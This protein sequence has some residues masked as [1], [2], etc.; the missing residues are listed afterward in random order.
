M[1]TRPDNEL[2]FYL[3][4]RG[5]SA[6]GYQSENGF[7]VR[8]NSTVRKYPTGAFQRSQSLMSVRNNLLKSG[9]LTERADDLLMTRDCEFGS[10]STAASLVLGCPANGRRAWK[11]ADGIPLAVTLIGAT[12]HA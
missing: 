4:A 12:Q 6:E 7:T 11:T 5:V 8:A 10:P 9:A 3:K 2:V 1:K